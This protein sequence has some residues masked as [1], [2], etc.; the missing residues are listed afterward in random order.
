MKGLSLI[1]G[2][3]FMAFLIAATAIIYWTAVPTVQKMQC[4][5]IVDKM[6]ASLAKTDEVIQRVASEGEGSRRTLDLNIEE[7]EMHVDGDNDTIYWEY[8]CNSPIFSPRTFQTFGNVVFGS[9]LNTK[10]YESACMGQNAFVIE[11]EHL[12]ACLKRIGSEGNNTPYNISDVLLSLYQKDLGQALPLEYLDITLDNNATSST[13]QGYTK[14]EKTGQHLPYGEVTA[15]LESD[16]G[17]TYNIKF[18][19]ESGEDF[20]TVKGG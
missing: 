5:I 1:S 16:Y 15:Y 8:E 13:G 19:L 2:V 11:N 14:L 20:L 3:L 18:I 7:G 9:N 10:A 12:K 17:V 4:S 6:K